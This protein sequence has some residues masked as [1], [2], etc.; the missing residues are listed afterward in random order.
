MNWKL[1]MGIIDILKNWIIIKFNQH[2]LFK[3][4]IT[5]FKVSLKNEVLILYWEL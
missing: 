1:I 4:N 5:I 2:F 3:K